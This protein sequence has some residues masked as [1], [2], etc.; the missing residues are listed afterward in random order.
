MKYRI[1]VV[2]T[3]SAEVTANSSDEAYEKYHNNGE[4]D[5]LVCLEEKTVDI[6][7]VGGQRDP[8][9][10]GSCQK[11]PFILFPKLWCIYE[12]P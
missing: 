8:S 6:D 10:G 1:V 2:Q 7:A 5:S 9:F 4:Y 3:W 11:P 12:N